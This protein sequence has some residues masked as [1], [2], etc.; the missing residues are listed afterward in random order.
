M[1][2]TCDPNT[3]PTQAKCF[4]CIPKSAQKA[5]E[6]Y[7]LAKIA[8][9]AT[10]YNGVAQIVANAKCFVK[11]VPGDSRDAVEIFLLAQIG[12]CS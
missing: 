1:A 6:L 2:F 7:L 10:D 4:T 8:G 11:C 9:L 5:V 12:G 3:L